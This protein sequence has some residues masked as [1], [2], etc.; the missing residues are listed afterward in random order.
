MSETD[1]QVAASPLLYDAEQASARLGTDSSG[2]PMVS[3]Y[4]LRRKAAK[5]LI[6][7]TY[8]GQSPRWSERDLL[9]LIEQ[10][11]QTPRG[12]GKSR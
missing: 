1:T 11:R 12:P 4:W 2:R 5:G 7:C 8:F 10:R 6:P 9:D 3:A